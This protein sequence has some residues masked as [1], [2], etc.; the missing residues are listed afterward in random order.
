MICKFQSRNLKYLFHKFKREVLTLFMEQSG[1]TVKV[2][3][4]LTFVN[5][6]ALHSLYGDESVEAAWSYAGKIKLSLAKDPN[7]VLTVLDP[8]GDSVKEM[9][10]APPLPLFRAREF[11][12]RDRRQGNSGEEK[13]DSVTRRES[14][15]RRTG[16]AIATAALTLCG[17][18][19]S[20]DS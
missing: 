15:A 12:R 19:D 14:V 2:V 16:S 6:Q 5:L 4:N 18:G 13:R 8:L 10:T 1:T 9:L 3:G 11:P 17:S 7:R 20:C